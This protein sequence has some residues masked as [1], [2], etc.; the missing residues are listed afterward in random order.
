MPVDVLPVADVCVRAGLQPFGITN[1]A[2]T[3][4]GYPA[5]TLSWWSGAAMF[6]FKDGKWEARNFK[7]YAECVEV[8]GLQE[9]NSAE[10]RMP[11]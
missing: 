6:Y 1:W 8:L 10:D 4:N 2:G 11:T 9:Q 3:Y 5:L 7:S